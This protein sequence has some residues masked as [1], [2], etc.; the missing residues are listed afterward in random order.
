M[1]EPV[2]LLAF[3]ILVFGVLLTLASLFADPLALGTPGSSFG[4]K[5][6]LG[7]VL[8]IGLTLLGAKLTGL[9]ERRR[10]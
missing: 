9:L 2:R 6:I 10:P 1:S 5:Q 3:F 8:G 4:W 7:T